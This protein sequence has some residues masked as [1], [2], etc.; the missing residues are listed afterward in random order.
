VIQYTPAELTPV[1]A[2]DDCTVTNLS[3]CNSKI[4]QFHGSILVG[5]NVGALDVSVYHTLVMQINQAI[6]NLGNVYRDQIFWEFSEP[7]ANIM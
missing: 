2:P 3:S 6:E 1:R 5:E 7:L 4:G